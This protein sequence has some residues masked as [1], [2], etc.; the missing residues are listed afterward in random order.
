MPNNEFGDFQTPLDLAKQCLRVLDLPENARVFEPT[1]G[2]GPFLEAAAELAPSSERF[3]VEINS[4][5]AAQ[6]SEWAQVRVANVFQLDLP[7]AAPWETDGPLFV[8]GNPPW[9]TS[10]ELK[11]MDSENLPLKENFKRVKGLDALL[12]SSNFDVCEYIILKALREFS[13]QSFVLGMLCKTQ[14]ARNVIEYAAAMDLPVSSAAIYRIDAMRWFDAGVDACWFTAEVNPAVEPDYTAA[15]YADIFSPNDDYTGRFGI[16]DSLLVSDVDKYVSVRQ[17][18]GKSPYVWRSGLKHDASSVFE[19]V[20][21]PEPTTKTGTRLDLEPEYVFPFLKSTDI[22]RGRHRELSKWVIVPQMEFGAETNHLRVMAP[23]L[24]HYLESNSTVLDGR[25][26]SIYR[27]RPRFSV[28]GHGDYTFA[29]YKVAVSGLHKQPLFQLVA[30]LNET[31]VVLDDTCYLLP[32]DDPTEA[33][34][35]AATLNSPACIALI[36]S[37]VFWDSKRPITKKLLS[38]LD[39]NRLPVDADVVVDQARALADELEI[40]FDGER[41]VGLIGSLGRSAEVEAALF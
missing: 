38:R 40:P 18:D 10:A 31:P 9:V 21:S 39:L 17:A 4:D 1:C 20:A 37:L 26:S 8:V 28:F 14:V 6:A 7:D 13:D 2:L 30:P 34:V 23:K 33:A 24:W 5:Y 19:L 41:A 25:K 36:E 32:F 16:V 29:P 35:V 27:N 12:G 22:F 11:R 15:T 3:G